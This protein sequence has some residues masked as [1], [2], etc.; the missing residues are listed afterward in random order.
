V[1][2]RAI[3]AALA[4]TLEGRDHTSAQRRIEAERAPAGSASDAE[5]RGLPTD[6]RRMAAFVLLARSGSHPLHHL[7]CPPGRH[8][9]MKA[10]DKAKAQAPQVRGLQ[11]GLPNA[12]SLFSLVF[13]L[14]S[15]D[16]A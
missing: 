4:E 6:D 11:C 7:S 16:G 13:L 8:W 15:T 3:P 1:A 10:K 5:K 14:L 2:S 12:V 9:P